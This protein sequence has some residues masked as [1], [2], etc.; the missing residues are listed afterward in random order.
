MNESVESLLRTLIEGQKGLSKQVTQLGVIVKSVEL[1]QTK[2]NNSVD[3]INDAVS[4]LRK[5]IQVLSSR[6]GVNDEDLTSLNTKLNRIL[7]M[8]QN[9]ERAIIDIS[10][11]TRVVHDGW[12][13]EASDR[14]LVFKELADELKGMQAQ[15]DKME[16]EK[17]AAGET[18]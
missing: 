11:D 10:H 5:D 4:S 2:L 15:I 7:R 9:A 14:R 6:V 13:E 12:I 1:E 17:L 3:K 18:S 8:V 16:S